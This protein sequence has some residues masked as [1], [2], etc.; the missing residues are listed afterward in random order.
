M[1]RGS[2]T[3]RF[4]ATMTT[5][6]P[7]RLPTGTVTFVF[8]DIEGST[9]LVQALG[10]PAWAALLDR[11]R[12]LVRAAITVAGGIEILTE[13]DSFFVVFPRAHD[14]V[15]AMAEVQRALAAEPWPPDAAIR[16][17]IGIH[18]GEG[19][20]DGEGD[21]IGTDVHRA[22]RIEAA[23][24]G[25]QTLVSE[26]TRALVASDLP[27][28][29]TIRD[30]GEHR[31][32]DLRPE[33]LAQLDIAGVPTDER[34]VRSLDSRPNNLPTQL[35][36]FVGREREVA[37][38]TELL[39][40]N[41]LLTLSGPGG[42]GKTRLS[43]QVAA[44][45]ADRFPDG[46]WWV[47]LEPIRDRSLV[48]PTIARTLGLAD[49]TSRTSLELLIDHIGGRRILLVLDNFEQVV[50]AAP[51]AADL[52]R[53]CPELRILVTSRTVLRVYGEQEYP[54][55]GL[56]APPDLRG[57]S[58]SDIANLPAEVRAPI[59][60]RWAGSRRYGCSSPVRSPRALASP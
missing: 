41:R 23:A 53:A 29:V 32:K 15:A 16:V 39:L 2:D 59:R 48:G 6:A 56:P 51:I 58:R 28:G 26:S 5:E 22:A 4:G 43:L 1:R 36:S 38:A 54:V 7:R 9:R 52:L 19:F 21:Y 44:D 47:P 8:T 45:V 57:M 30:V 55:P 17:R 20:V 50:D 49:S 60:R 24:N 34:P 10:A 14:A 31:L 33:R 3:D 11:H 25:G 18:T 27:P 13:G 37:E 12:E 42:T 46:V 40:A 35:T